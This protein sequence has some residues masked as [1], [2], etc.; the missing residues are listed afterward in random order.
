[1][2]G[3]LIDS[4]P[5]VLKAWDTFGAEYKLSNPAAVAH[6]TLGRRL[7]DTLKEYCGIVA[8]DLI[9][10]EIDRFENE[11]IL[12]GPTPLPGAIDLVAKLMSNPSS[13]SRWTIVTSASDKYAP[14]AL[15]RS[16][17]P[18]PLAGI[19]TSNDVSEG[20]PHPAPYLAGAVLCAVDPKRCMCGF[21]RE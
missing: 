3:T 14:R 16:G 19:I 4:T 8:E 20:K 12:G 2:D 17:I 9:Q 1:M 13:N 18:V 10:A 6:A 5:G 7:Y 21:Y 11:V 15:E